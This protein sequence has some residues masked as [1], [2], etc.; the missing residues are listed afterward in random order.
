MKCF[1]CQYVIP[2]TARF[3]AYCG[4]GIPSAAP[5]P[6]QPAAP[7][8]PASAPSPTRRSGLVGFML[9]YKAL[10]IFFGLGVLL[11]I[12]AL[13]YTM[14]SGDETP[15]QTAA[16]AE[17]APAAAAAPLLAPEPT[18][19]PTPD[20]DREALMALYNATDGPNWLYGDGWNGPGPISDWHGVETD[21]DGRVIGLGFSE[22]QLS[23]EIPP[24]L[25][26]L[27]NLE[28]LDLY[29]N[30]LSGEIPSQ[31][32]S[33]SN[34]E[35]LDLSF[36]QLSGEIPSELGS[37]ANLE[38]LALSGN[39]LSGE[40]PSELGS[41]T[42][43]KLLVLSF[44][45]LSG[46]IPSE[47]GNLANLEL[48]D[49][50]GNQLSG[51]VP[52]NLEGRVQAEPD[53]LPFCGT[54]IATPTPTAPPLPTAT[55]IPTNTPQPPPTPTPTATPVPTATPT[56]IPTPTPTA[57]LQSRR[58]RQPLHEAWTTATPQLAS[59]RTRRSHRQHPALRPLQSRRLRPYP[60]GSRG[61]RTPAGGTSGVTR[62]KCRQ[63]GEWVR[64]G[65]LSS[66]NGLATL[67]VT[68]KDYPEELPPQQFAEEHRASLI[69]QYG[70][71]AVFFNI[72]GF[73]G[74][75]LDGH[76]WFRL[77]W[78]VQHS[79]DSCVLNVTDMIARSR[80]FP[81]WDHGYIVSFRVCDDHL[82]SHLRERKRILE[83]IRELSP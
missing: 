38:L 2:N 59:L 74:V 67:T 70:F 39:Q 54:P 35:A 77:T 7:P 55:P 25:A 58:H 56:P 16:P 31:L 81:S 80:N 34:L 71:D 40:I 3:C 33:L 9:E 20:T 44:N 28:A 64:G 12:G 37:L 83:S 1:N 63:T 79:L 11:L 21:P 18:E 22:N 10:S 57:T 14:T 46:E 36:N 53:G 6:T 72:L 27:S 15:Q 47:L 65:Q 48:L 51:C 29:G 26:N 73:Q 17:A 50:S 78:R 82:Q 66:P 75:P 23:G 8:S 13:F 62:W 52:G 76:Q 30:Q 41:L 69:D 45:Q 32:G 4:A 19:T 5:P 42:N 61:R 24:Q 68:V 49:F 60:H 43:L